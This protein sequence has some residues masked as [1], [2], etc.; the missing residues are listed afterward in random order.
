MNKDNLN[1]LLMGAALVAL[2]YALYRHHAPSQVR[3]MS[4]TNQ[5]NF[6]GVP[7]SGNDPTRPA[8]GDSYDPAAPAA[9][10]LVSDLLKG[11]VHDIVNNDQSSSYMPYVSDVVS[12]AV[13][14]ATNPGNVGPQD[15]IIRVPGALW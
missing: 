15:S 7:Y 6:A 2:A 4:A 11:S 1:D 14:D 8:Q 9:F 3:P 10:M 5:A 12:Q 13:T